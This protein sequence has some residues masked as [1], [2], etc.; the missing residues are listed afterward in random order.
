MIAIVFALLLFLGC[1]SLE[2]KPV[3]LSKALG[4]Y[5][6]TLPAAGWRPTEMD[7]ADIAMQHKEKPIA[8]AI[9][10]PSRLKESLPLDVLSLHLLLEIKDKK[11]LQKDYVTLDGQPAIHT[12]LEGR[13]EVER[14][15]IESYVVARAGLVYDIVY[16]ASPVYFQEFRKD[17]QEVVKSFS[18]TEPVVGK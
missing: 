1:Q 7:G 4:T 2:E 13:V 3:P 15:R 8:F 18:F 14:V 9:F 5:R 6:V 16:W 11:V 17:F 10:S 12:V